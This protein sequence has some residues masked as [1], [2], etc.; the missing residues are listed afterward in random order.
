MASCASNDTEV[1]LYNDAAITAFTLGK[2]NHYK[3]TEDA[4]GLTTI[5]ITSFTASSYKFIID[6]RERK[7]YNNDSLPVGTDAAH[8]LC[9]ITTAKNGVAMF[10]DLKE[11]DTWYI[12]SSRDSIDFTQPRTVR[13]VSSDGGGYTEYEVRVNVHKQEGDSIE[14]ELMDVDFPSDPVLPQGIKQLLGG[15]DIEEYALSDK[16]KLM[17]SYDQGMTWTQDIPDTHE[18]IDEVPTKDVALV[19]Y[20]MNMADRTMYVLMAGTCNGSI[21][22]WRKIVDLDWGAPESSWSYMDRAGEEEFDLPVLSNLSLVYYDKS[23]L[24][25][26]GDYKTIYQSRDN[27]ITWKTNKAY[28]MP[29]DFD[30]QVESVKVAVDEE[31]YIWLYCKLINGDK[32]V[33]RGRLNRLGWFYQ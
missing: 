2:L 21:S 20:P 12:Y 18:D 22:V 27:G 26:G 9:N 28:V 33:W 3:V 11:E 1:T 29:K 5:N 23:I 17:V 7:I 10:K 13:V 24:A 32:Q 25:F 8:V 31:D 15:F 16:N 6:Q 14:W 19:T 4:D 30:Y